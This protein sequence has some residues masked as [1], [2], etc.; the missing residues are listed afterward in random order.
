MKDRRRPVAEIFLAAVSLA[1]TSDRSLHTRLS[2]CVNP[3]LPR[4]LC[5][6]FFS[7]LA[8]RWGEVV[9]LA[10]TLVNTVA[11]AASKGCHSFGGSSPFSSER[12]SWIERALCDT[13]TDVGHGGCHGGG[14]VGLRRA[15]ELTF[16]TL[17]AGTTKE[18]FVRLGVLAEGTV[19]PSDMLSNLW[20]QVRARTDDGAAKEQPRIPHVC[21]AMLPW[22]RRAHAFLGGS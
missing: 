19:A 5:F 12:Y 3:P 14:G 21:F 2:T 15:I 18:C 10:L 6:F 9:P 20:D 22:V 16:N 13:D 11:A 4:P 1:C 17:L 7:Q 8:K